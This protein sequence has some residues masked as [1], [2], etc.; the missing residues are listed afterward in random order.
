MDLVESRHC[1]TL[2]SAPLGSCSP[3]RETAPGSTGAVLISQVV[4]QVSG[5]RRAPPGRRRRPFRSKRSLL[6]SAAASRCPGRSEERR[7]G[8]ECRFRLLHSNQNKGQPPIADMSS[9]SRSACLRSDSASEYGSVG[10]RQ[11]G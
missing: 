4:S 6:H 3:V 10:K 7:V 2:A 8:K 5:S 11:K 1:P 9:Y